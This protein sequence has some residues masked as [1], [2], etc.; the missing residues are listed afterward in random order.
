[1]P[2][3][4][5]SLFRRIWVRD[6]LLL[7][8]GLVVFYTLWLGHY[9]LFTPDEGRYSEVARE[10]VATGDY[11][12]PRVDGVAFLDKPVLYYW[13]QATA[14]QWFGLKEW[15]LRFFPA[16]LGVLGCLV[17][18]LAGFYLFNRRTGLLSAL[19]LATTPLYFGGAHYADLNL[20]VAV[21]I[22]CTLLFFICGVQ[23]ENPYRTFFLFAAYFSAACA[24]LTKGLI[25]LAFPG[26]IAGCWMLLLWRIDLL[27]R[28][29]LFKG[30]LF[31][32]A[33]TLPWY[34]LVQK[35][36][37]QFFHY[38]FITQQVT[39]FLST[40]V[41]NN[42]T[43]YWF[44]VPVV[45]A[46]FFPWTIFLCQA[47]FYHIKRIWR[48]RYQYQTELFLFLWVL[49][50]LGFFSVPQSKTV[51]YIF[52]IFPALALLVGHY[53]SATW[54]IT[55]QTLRLTILFFI[56]ISTLLSAILF[57]LPHYHLIHFA[58]GFAPYLTALACVFLLSAFASLCFLKHNTWQSLFYICTISS[59]LFLIILL[60]GA[61]YLNRGSTKTL[62]LK[63]KLI[64]SPQDEVIT[65]QRYYQDLPLYL[66]KRVTIVA[67]WHSPDIA[68]NDN[69]ERELWYGM[70]FQNTDDWLINEKIFWQRFDSTKRVFVLTSSNYLNQFHAHGKKYFILDKNENL[71]L[72]SNQPATLSKNP[73]LA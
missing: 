32:I 9:A 5:F 10:M 2:S 41:F 56:A 15:A 43:P 7:S 25:G 3:S 22:S 57:F 36:N 46:G 4:T 29:H 37:P 71:V 72:L 39:R 47:L 62:A 12:T 21:F 16:L 33:L 61:D 69:W 13:L 48:A 11:I 49:I 28:I 27:K 73:S 23:R 8:I 68:R 50:I 59:I 51:G 31:F 70:A 20:E 34:L 35:A 1:M 38:F 26:M 24:F 54:E 52:P 58:P 60:S 64:I 14:I 44:Y 55:K 17:T 45:L 53:L 6:L 19:I 42:K 40:G 63:L 18:Y 66:E 65:Y 67:D 30:I